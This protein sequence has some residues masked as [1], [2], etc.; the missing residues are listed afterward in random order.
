MSVQKKITRKIDFGNLTAFITS[1]LNVIPTVIDGIIQAYE[2]GEKL[3]KFKA[4]YRIEEIVIINHK[5]KT[6]LTLSGYE[7]D[8]L[9][10]SLADM[11]IDTLAT[12][13]E[14]Y[15]EYIESL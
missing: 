12:A 11:K 13:E 5:D 4:E 1:R 15:V 9:A 6:I 7:G 2:N 10:Q 3:K 8:I 14:L